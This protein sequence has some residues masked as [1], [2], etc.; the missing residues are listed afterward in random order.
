[1]AR[2]MVTKWLNQGACRVHLAKPGEGPLFTGY[3][4]HKG[5]HKQEGRK[6][7][8]KQQEGRLTCEEFAERLGGT[9]E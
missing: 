4:D 7:L 2:S 1:M 5:L 6:G 8:R 9:W 3:I